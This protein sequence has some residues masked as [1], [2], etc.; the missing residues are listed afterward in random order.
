MMLSL[1]FIGY[2]SPNED[3]FE[4]EK[5]YYFTANKFTY[6][7]NDTYQYFKNIDK[8]KQIFSTYIRNEKF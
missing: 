6:W 2:A 8:F 5:A 4:D 1:V 3:K 7:I